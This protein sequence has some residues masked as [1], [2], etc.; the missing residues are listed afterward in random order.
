MRCSFPTP[1][2]LGLTLLFSG[3]GL[4]WNALQSWEFEA[5]GNTEGWSANHAALGVDGGVLSG[6]ISAPDPQIT[7]L[8]PDFS[9][10]ASSGIL[11]RYRGSANGRL[12]LFWGRQGA[13]NYSAARSVSVTYSGNG[14]W[15][16]LYL[17]PNGH[18][19]WDGQTVTRLRVDPAGTKIALEAG[20]A[21]G[22]HCIHAELLT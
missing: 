7:R 6:S 4:A 22:K 15:Q 11:V 19:E 18:G 21:S 1:A 14:D 13:D 16:T 10:S 2:I 20:E 3:R 12:D 8:D 9:G 5:I 17:N